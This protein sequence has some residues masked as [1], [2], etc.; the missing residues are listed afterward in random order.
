MTAQHNGMR[1]WLGVGLA[2]IL[3]LSGWVYSAGSLSSQVAQNTKINDEQKLLYVPRTEIDAKLENLQLQV[4]A[5]E[6]K[7][8]AAAAQSARQTA[9][10]IRR[11]ERLDTPRRNQ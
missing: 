7:V 9:L 8:D 3:A 6:G 4:G 1:V 5:V 10:I 2:L 11:I